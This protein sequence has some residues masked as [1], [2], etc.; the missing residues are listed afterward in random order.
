MVVLGDLASCFLF[1]ELSWASRESLD[2]TGR[3]SYYPCFL[4]P[5]TGLQACNYRGP[6]SLVL[7]LGWLYKHQE[8]ALLAQA[9]LRGPEIPLWRAWHPNQAG[10]LAEGQ[11]AASR[12]KEP[13]AG[14]KDPHARVGPSYQLGSLHLHTQDSPE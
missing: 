11:D 2:S 14:S 9:I 8:Q 12:K 3:W 13:E 10:Y 6:A 1:W 4:S 5:A 7:E